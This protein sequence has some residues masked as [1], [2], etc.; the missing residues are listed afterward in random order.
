M[1]G[2]KVETLKRIDW[3]GT[4]GLGLSAV[5]LAGCA[6][7]PR[8]FSDESSY[9]GGSSESAGGTG[10]SS[11]IPFAVQAGKKG[12]KLHAEPLDG[13]VIDRDARKPGVQGMKPGEWA[14]G[15]GW[16][17]TGSEGNGVMPDT[18]QMWVQVEIGKKS[19]EADVWVEMS[20]LTA[21]GDSENPGR[22]IPQ[23]S[24]YTCNLGHVS[25]G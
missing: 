22:I 24:V 13:T 17:G 11:C 20:D 15:I 2:E 5:L 4:L 25:H 8:V 19:T 6:G 23:Q 18:R 16:L 14:M 7:A 21:G 9:G 3:R 12:A 1:A 10:S